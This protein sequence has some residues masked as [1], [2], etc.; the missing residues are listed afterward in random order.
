MNMIRALISECWQSK[1]VLYD[2][3]IS[4]I[5]LQLDEKLVEKD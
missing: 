4:E 3:K 5:K 1:I 2:Q